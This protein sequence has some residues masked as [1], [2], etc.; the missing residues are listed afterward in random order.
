MFN[1][2]KCVADAIRLVGERAVFHW[3]N[4]LSGGPDM[5][6]LDRYG[7]SSTRDQKTVIVGC[8]I[9]S[10]LKVVFER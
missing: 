1:C 9:E 7:C 5:N 8:A 3:A 6:N 10:L 2:K 4:F